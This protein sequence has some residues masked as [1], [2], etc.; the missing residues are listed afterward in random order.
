MLL[1][2]GSLVFMFRSAQKERALAER[3][4]DFLANVTHELKTPLS[5][6]QAAGENLADGRVQ[7]QQRLKNYGSHIFSEAV[8]LRKM[9]DK[10]LDVAKANAGESLVEP[11]PTDIGEVVKSF[12]EKHRKF[13]R[14]KDVTLDIDIDKNLPAVNID[15]NS[16]QTMLSNL[17]DNAIKYSPDEKYLGIRV[18]KENDLLKLCIEDHGVGIAR[19]DLSNI[20]TKFYRVEDSLTAKTKGHGLGLSIVKNLVELNSG[21]ID[22]ESEL[23]DGST[24]IITFPIL[25]ASDQKAP[26]NSVSPEPA[27]ELRNKEFEQHV[28]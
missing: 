2:L 25:S 4:A 1:L 23:G 16:L 14:D 11:Q 20:F 13:F 21:S 24:F 18:Y 28:S 7:D 3:Q 22:V 15:R 27:K 5:V 26:Q 19:K 9:I 6:M 8:R 10:L 17:V 12:L